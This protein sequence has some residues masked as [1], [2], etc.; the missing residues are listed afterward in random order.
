MSKL[1]SQQLRGADLNTVHR[2]DLGKTL[3]RVRM[4]TLTDRA[5][6]H[7]LM[8]CTAQELNE[9]NFKHPEMSYPASGDEQ[10]LTGLTV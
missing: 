6:F 10:N 3:E 9:Q 2:T 8:R 5:L 4:S 1:P 7:T